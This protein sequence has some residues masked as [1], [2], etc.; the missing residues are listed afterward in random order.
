MTPRY[1]LA[2][3]KNRMVVPVLVVYPARVPGAMPGVVEISWLIPSSVKR[4][5]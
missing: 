5:V 1:V 4:E 2:G 3:L